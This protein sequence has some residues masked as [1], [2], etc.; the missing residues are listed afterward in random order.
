MGTGASRPAVGAPRSQP[1]RKGALSS[2]SQPRSNP[3]QVDTV[4]QL[5]PR[6]TRTP[7]PFTPSIPRQQDS[8]ALLFLALA[9]PGPMRCGEPG[10]N[11]SLQKPRELL[12]S[13]NWKLLIV[14]ALRMVAAAPGLRGRLWS[15]SGSRFGLEGTE[16]RL[17]YILRG[18]CGQRHWPGCSAKQAAATS[19]EVDTLA[20]WPTAV[21]RARASLERLVFFTQSR[22]VSPPLVWQ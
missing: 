15:A 22:D 2:Q 18:L 3:L 5:A 16:G 1:D 7:C 6:D 13:N 20:G 4:T 9:R 10:E 11:P 19:G 17:G 8:P 21:S 12:Q 14:N